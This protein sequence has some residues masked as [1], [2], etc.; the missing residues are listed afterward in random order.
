MFYYYRNCCL[1]KVTY[2]GD[3][4]NGKKVG[5]WYLRHQDQKMVFGLNYG[6]YSWN[7]YV[8]Y[9]GQYKNDNRVGKWDIWQIIRCNNIFQ[10]DIELILQRSGQYDERGEKFDN[11]V[12]MKFDIWYK[13]QFTLSGEYQNGKKV[14]IW[15]ELNRNEKLSEIIY[16][17]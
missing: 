16:D 5:L 9:S 11:W 14:G 8:T 2:S 17:Y 15:I 10:S 12:E 7:A 1:K 4:K 13:N 6:D 3:Y